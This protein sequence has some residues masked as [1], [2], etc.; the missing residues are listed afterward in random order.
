MQFIV[1]SEIS[2][3]EFLLDE[4]ESFH[5]KKVLRLKIGDEV[6]VFD[7]KNK[8]VCEIIEFKNDK[9][10]LR[11]IIKIQ[12]AVKKIKLNLYFPFIE[13]KHFEYVLK[14]ATEIGVDSFTP[15][16][17]E[18]TQKHFVFDIE[19]KKERL[20]EIIKSAVKQSER[21]SFPEIKNPINFKDI[22]EKNIKIMVMS[23]TEINGKL[24]KLT[25]ALE[26]FKDE[27]NVL[28]GPEGGFS[29]SELSYMKENF[30]P[31][32]ISDNVLRSETAAIGGV[33]AIIGV[34]GGK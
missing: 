29:E 14:T 13:K 3:K 21:D 34:I 1:S 15:I 7:G 30:Y 17:S 12:S 33:C 18:Y 25:E 23:K 5:L 31:V 2:N 19:S 8:W 32:K 4:E 10:F 28:I 9:V 20:E 22:F 24:F 6:K 26:N 16:I 27:I 11:P